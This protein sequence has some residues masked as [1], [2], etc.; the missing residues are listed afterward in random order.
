MKPNFDKGLKKTIRL[1]KLINFILISV[2]TFILVELVEDYLF[3]YF[4]L[5]LSGIKFGWLAFFLF[6]G[7][8]YHV[9]CC[10]IPLIWAAYQCRHKKCDHDHCN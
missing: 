9:I 8:K 10:L 2:L 7:F 4:G 1:G 6:Y 5:D 3:K